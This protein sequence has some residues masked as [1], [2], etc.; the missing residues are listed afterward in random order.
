MSVG[1]EIPFTEVQQHPFPFLRFP[2]QAEAGEEVFERRVQALSAQVE[3]LK[4]IDYYF[5][6]RWRQKHTKFNDVIRLR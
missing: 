1:L 2:V 6:H 5:N 3:V 4:I